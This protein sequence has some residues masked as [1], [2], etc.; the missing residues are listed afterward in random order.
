[1][2]DGDYIEH[3][4][5]CSIARLPAVLHQP[6]QGLPLEGLRA[7]RGV[8]HREGPRARQRAAAARGRADPV[9]ALDARLHR[10]A[11]TSCSRRATAWSRRPSSRPTTRRSR[12]TASSRST[13]ATTTSSS[14]CARRSRATTILMVSRRRPGR[15]LRGVRRPRDGPRHQRRARHERRARRTTTSSRWTSRATGQDL[16]VVTENGF[17]KRT[18]IDEYRMTGRGTKGV[19][20]ITLTEAQGR[21]RRRARGARARRARL[22]LPRAAWSSAPS[23]RGHQPL[24]PR[25]AG[26]EGDE[27]ARGRRRQRRRARR[28]LRCG[29]RRS[30]RR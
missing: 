15:A 28:R 24:R 22:H 11:S 10:G 3:L 29:R 17:G 23:V 9:R 18:A 1:M 7:A 20:T 12:P 27:H 13:S 19:K 6:R 8:A 16:L 5:V 4:F 2:K 25:V 30:D 14:P 26:R 21:P